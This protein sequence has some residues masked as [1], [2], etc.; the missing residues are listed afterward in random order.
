LT[1]TQQRTGKTPVALDFADLDAPLIGAFLEHLE[2]VRANSVSTRN[3]RLAAVHSFFG[4]AAL[5]HPEHAGL[6]QRVLAIPPKRVD[7]L[8]V[9]FLTTEEVDA[10][11]A[12]PDRSRWHGRRDHALLVVAV[13]TRP[14]G[15]RT[16]PADLRRRTARG[17]RARPLFR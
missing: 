6:I 17:R 4:F 9:S 16:H 15:L 14:A 13:T 1:F 10:L 3:A 12:A 5:R 11:L 8:D 7:R 2:Q